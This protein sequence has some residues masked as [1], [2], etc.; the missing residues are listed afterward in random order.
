MVVIWEIAMVVRQV[1]FVI[2]D[3]WMPVGR[4]YHIEQGARLHAICFHLEL[5]TMTL[6]ELCMWLL[7]TLAE[8]G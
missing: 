8:R 4:V 7:N 1:F 5:H 6:A 2:G 3:W